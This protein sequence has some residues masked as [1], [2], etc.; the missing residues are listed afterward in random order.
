MLNYVWM[1][2]YPSQVHLITGMSIRDTLLA[3]VIS[4]GVSL[5]LLPF[6]G[7]LADRLGRRPVLIGFAVDEV[8]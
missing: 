1:V 7:K 5:V 6:A 4:V 2:S 3:G 8:R